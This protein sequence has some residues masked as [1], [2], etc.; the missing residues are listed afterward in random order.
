MNKDFDYSVKIKATDTG[1]AVLIKQG[2]EYYL[3]TAA[4]ICEKQ[5]EDCPTKIIGIDGSEKEFPNLKRVISPSKTGADICVMK[6]PAEVAIT[7][8]KNVKCASFEGSGFPCE[9]DGYPLNACDKG[10]R[11][12]TSCTIAKE[13]EIGEKLYVK[14]GE[15][16]TD[17]QKL[18]NVEC[19][20][21]GSG[22]FVDSNGEKYLIGIIFQVDGVRNLFVGWKMQKIN[23]IL[24]NE[25][26]KEIPLIPIELRQ[27]IID[28]YNSL[29]K[30]TNFVLSRIHNKIIGNVQ[31]P[32]TAYKDKIEN[33][34]A[35]AQVVIITGEAGIGKSALAKEVLTSTKYKSVAIV[36]DDLDEEQENSILKHWEICDRLQDIYKS[37]IWGEGDK[38][39][40][41]ES[42]E[43]MLNGNT[44]TAIVFIENLLK[45]IP[46]LKMVFTIRKNVLDLFRVVLH[47]NGIKVH[48]ES[49]IE[50]G[51]LDD[52]ELNTVEESIPTIKSFISTNETREIL[53]NP[54]YL[55]LACSITS[56]INLDNLN[57]SEFKDM[58]CRQIVAG[59]HHNPIIA[60]QR[61]EALKGIAKRTS[62]SGMNLVKCEMSEAILSLLGDD[63]LVGDIETGL[64]RPS[65]DILTDWGLYCSIDECYC[66]Y[67][68]KTINIEEFY[69]SLDK[70]VA[71][72]NMFK[73]YIETHISE[74]DLSLG[75]FISES[76]TLEKYHFYQDDLFY[77][78]LNSDKG[79]S[80]LSLIK[81]VL[82]ENDS[83]VLK[84]IAK[85]LYY[86]FRKVNWDVKEFLMKRGVIEKGGKIRN[87][88]YIMPSGKGWYVF[89]TFLYENRDA[90]NSLREELIPLLLQC[91]LVSIT[92]EEAPNLKKYVFSILADD[93]ER[94]LSEDESY[95]KPDKEVIRLLFKWM[96]ENP[97][98]IKSWVEKALVTDSYEFDVIKNFLLLS[99][100]IDA[101]DFI[102]RYPE[103][104][105]SLI[106]KEWL[107][108]DG[109]V[110]DYY[111][112]IHQA[113]G[114][115]TTYKCFF[116]SNPED[117][118]LFLC[119]LLNYDIEKAKLN[120]Q[121]N[122][123]EI[124]VKLQDKEIAIWGNDSLWRDYRGGNYHSHVRECLLMTFE[125]WLMDSINKHINKAKYALDKETLLGFFDIVYNQCVN[126]SAWG[127]LASVATRFPVFVGMKAMPI[128]SCR[129]F[130]LW[131]KTRL[132]T[133]SMRPMINSYASK[134]ICKEV[135]DSYNLPHRKKDLEWVILT[136]SITEGFAEEF[137]KLVKSFKDTAT[138]Y[139]EKVSASRMD[140]DQYKVVG[141]NDEVFVLQGSPADDIK[142]EA[143]QTNKLNEQFNRIIKTTNISRNHYD[144][145][146]SYDI[147]EWR[148]AY[149]VHKNQNGFLESK[150]LIA[151]LGVKKY[152]DK[153]V[154]KERKWCREILLEDTMK[155][156]TS[157]Q[158]QVD[159]EYSSD[160]LLYLLDRRRFK[161]KEIKAIVYLIGSIREN[162]T[163][164]TRFENTFKG[165]IWRK[166]EKLAKKIILKYI[167]NTENRSDDVD[168]FAHVCKLLPTDIEDDTI[169]KLVSVYCNQFFNKWGEESIRG[170][171]RF[172][173]VRVEEFCAEYMLAMPLK[174]K[175]FVETWLASGKK[176]GLRRYSTEDN[177]ISSV[178][179]NY[180]YL[181]TAKNKDLF[182]QLWEIMFEWYKANNSKEVLPSV[183]I[184]FNLMRI[185]LLDNWE[186]LEGSRDHL[187]KLLAILPPEGTPYLTR[188]VCKFGFN[189]LMPESL[190]YIN[191]DVLRKAIIESRELCLWQNAAEDLYDDAKTRDLIRRD[192]KLRVAY[193]ELLNSLINRGSAI[194]YMIRDYYIVD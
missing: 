86:M 181:A 101:A 164:F 27:H 183:M 117:A 153:L 22:V 25:G 128:Y 3:L 91:E 113:S 131:D 28:Q 24:N 137:R 70:N 12:E 71:F 108:K 68:T 23:E 55:N 62:A 123:Q 107:D 19:G 61:I 139:L 97:E 96:D 33:A 41:V 160:G 42:A 77:A 142:E 106:R 149:Q 16:R 90:F 176:K 7:I 180:C 158:Y 45:D 67:K 8:S 15:S 150:G 34:I 170:Y 140:I 148:E 188:L 5:A 69:E 193:V 94:I 76:L 30:Y 100:T 114:V 162:D 50:V 85:A 104:Y 126:V 14:L 65:H 187:N 43:R 54:F 184:N 93:V 122:L 36:G 141:K 179:N 10:M 89:V 66:K 178:F 116:Y 167:E 37:A 9:I 191:A 138:T 59:K 95:E 129:D 103:L 165:L 29:I 44:D 146:N 144:D 169:D 83:F 75:N 110:E 92:Q 109:I 194:A 171:S 78:I 99:E 58:L 60:S 80:F 35:K 130:I 13:S 2:G 186:V 74:G 155:Y 175:A 182:W 159:S 79:S 147:T 39:L 4:H 82:L 18:E 88:D 48:D 20:F 145:S 172:T 121:N 115:T 152:W 190:R 118:V 143:E 111:P 21:S 1:S 31:L 11:I 6:I 64:F 125:K 151:A 56:T 185:D 81:P 51:I 73:Q 52:D 49:V 174:R 177:L 189:S 127:V 84:K 63:V 134:T 163:L 47:A 17:G 124:K 166:D 112:I 53:R 136:L 119:E 135:A 161:R 26:W 72:R 156:V 46:N 168:K 40:L 102:Y 105:K 157:G 87:S 120:Q 173:D 98:L 57:G 38:A 132:S 192:E 32:R 154:R 133:E